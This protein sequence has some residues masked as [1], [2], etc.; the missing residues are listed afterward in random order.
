L[1]DEWATV[2]P[3]LVDFL[4]APRGRHRMRDTFR[5]AR[6]A[7]ARIIRAGQRE[8]SFRSG[9][10]TALATTVLACLDGLFLQELV[11]PGCTRGAR[12]DLHD[13]VARVL[14]RGGA[15]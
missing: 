9:S 2:G 10:P 8:G 1:F 5:T 7:L 11:E 13:S 12:G 6:G 4:R 3:L 14:R 15:S